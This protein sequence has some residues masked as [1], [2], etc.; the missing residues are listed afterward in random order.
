VPARRGDVDS[1]IHCL[2]R[3]TSLA[4]QRQS[5]GGLPPTHAG[6]VP[7]MEREILELLAQPAL[8]SEPIQSTW[9]NQDV[10]QESRANRS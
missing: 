4:L 3:R 6:T 8:A 9:A 5:A 7:N 2:R 10:L 1:V